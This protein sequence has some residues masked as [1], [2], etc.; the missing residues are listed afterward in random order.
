MNTGFVLLQKYLMTPM[1]KISQFKIVRAVMAAGM[2]SVPFC[3]VG[4]MFLV[5]NT[6]PMTFTGLETVFEN[7]IFKVS[8][9]YMIANTATMGI[10]ALYFNIVVGYEL[11]KIEEEETGLKVNALNGAM[12]SVFAFVMTLPELVMQSGAMV[13]LNDQSELVFN[14]LR[15]KPFVYRLG[16]SGIFIAIVMAIIATQLYFLCVR[17]NWVVKMPETV[18]LGVSRSFTALI[19]TFVIA[20]TILI[21]NGILVYFGTDIFDIIGVPFT[22]VTNLTKSWLGIMV[23][24]FLIHAL[25]VVGIHGASIIGAFITPIM[26]S[27]MN[28]NVGG[29]HIP[30]AGEFNNSLVILG[31]SGSTLLMTFF[32]AFC[33]KSSQLKILG[34][35]SAVPA[36][37]NINEPIIFGMPI[38][39]NPYLALPFL[40][41]PMACGTL[42]YFAIS[43]GFM[44]PIIAL[45]PWPSPMGLGAFIGTGGDYR[46]MFVA[47]L[48]AILALVIYLPF[49]K[50]YDNKL[51]KE[52]QAKSDNQ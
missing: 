40:L 39:Y 51:Y 26:L 20:F 29:A 50:M 9:L 19:P 27:N 3:I 32:I 31:G 37:F 13:L 21:L 47:I 48:S 12:L 10:L 33:A 28:E 8:D 35:A 25:W 34:R 52:E 49:V 43:S 44:N 41:A 30:F 18:P 14:G 38:V 42:G 36:I 7:T 4:S 46:A 24:L 5:F 17:R 22:F 2:A 15:L 11:T 45:I 6:L 23:I 16:T 1:A